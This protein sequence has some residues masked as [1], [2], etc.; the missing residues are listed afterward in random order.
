M[1]LLFLQATKKP[2]K[3][4]LHVVAG[5]SQ[6]R[7]GQAD[8]GQGKKVGDHACKPVVAVDQINVLGEIVVAFE[9]RKKITNAVSLNVTDLEKVRI[10]LKVTSNFCAKKLKTKQEKILKKYFL[11]PQF[12]VSYKNKWQKRYS[13]DNRKQN[14]FNSKP[15]ASFYCLPLGKTFYEGA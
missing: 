13:H 9:A 2:S 4:Q 11:R 1:N 6:N 3:N 8:A 10:M 12:F 15:T 5:S 7:F 14:N